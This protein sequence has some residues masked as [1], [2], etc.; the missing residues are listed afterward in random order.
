MPAQKELAKLK[1]RRAAAYLNTELDRGTLSALLREVHT[2]H[3]FVWSTNAG[4]VL[5]S[6]KIPVTDIAQQVGMAGR[7]LENN[8]DE[9]IKMLESASKQFDS[10]SYRWESQARQSEAK[11]RASTAARKLNEATAK[12][13]TIR[14]RI[15]PVQSL[16]RR[17]AHSLNDVKLRRQQQAADALTTDPAAEDEAGEV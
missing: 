11:L 17:A 15:V 12:H 2:T 10:A 8:L 4:G 1:P 13:N 9:A 5:T 14:T 7:I 16:F 6:V 3:F